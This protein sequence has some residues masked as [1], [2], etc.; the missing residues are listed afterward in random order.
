MTTKQKWNPEIFET[1]VMKTFELGPLLKICQNKYG[2]C[3]GLSCHFEKLSAIPSFLQGCKANVMQT[4]PNSNKDR[5]TT[6]RMRKCVAVVPK[7][8][9][10]EITNIVP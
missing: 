8:L 5:A 2:T 9:V 7:R 3:I 4:V 1:I 10:E 6:E